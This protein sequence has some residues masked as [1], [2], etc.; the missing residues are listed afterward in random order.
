[1][2]WKSAISVVSRIIV[3]LPCNREK[4]YKLNYDQFNSHQ[5]TLIFGIFTSITTLHGKLQCMYDEVFGGCSLVNA[6]S[7][8]TTIPRWMQM[9][10]FISSIGQM[11]MLCGLF[12]TK[13]DRFGLYVRPLVTLL[14]SQRPS[15]AQYSQSGLSYTQCVLYNIQPSWGLENQTIVQCWHVSARSAG[16]VQHVI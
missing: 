2:F 11:V 3:R 7:I 5:L 12:K 6:V 4:L 15:G 8:N 9:T 16:A 13:L 1:M 10:M 14:L